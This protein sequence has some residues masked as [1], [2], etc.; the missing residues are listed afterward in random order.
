[1]IEYLYRC[2]TK[3]SDAEVRAK[4][5]ERGVAVSVFARTLVK[6]FDDS[7]AE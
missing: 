1:M 7:T 5:F 4:E 2:D 3:N 6:A